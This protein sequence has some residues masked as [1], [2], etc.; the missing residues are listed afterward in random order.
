M[1]HPEGTN[2]TGREN[3]QLAAAAGEKERPGAADQQ[4]VVDT[5]P[6]VAPPPFK[7]PPTSAIAGVLIREWVEGR[8]A[9]RPTVQTGSNL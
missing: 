7:V 5:A 9:V 4:D 2:I 1:D 8:I 3:K 6:A